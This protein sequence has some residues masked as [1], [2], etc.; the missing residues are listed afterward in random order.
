MDGIEVSRQI[1]KFT[2]TPIIIL[3]VRESEDDKVTALDEGADDY[4][5]KP[6]GMDELLARVR[7]AMRHSRH[8]NLETVFS[9]G[10]LRVDLEHHHVTVAGREISLTPKEYQLLQLLVQ[11]AGKVLTHHY[12]LNEI[13]GKAYQS[14]NHLL[15]VNMSN[16]RQKIEPDPTRPRYILTELGVG[17]RLYVE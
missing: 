13:W 17:Y 16:L 12:L 1:R 3:S 10:D 9:V 15:R 4:L 5:C 6:F 14:E 7:V 11:N 8:A 2:K